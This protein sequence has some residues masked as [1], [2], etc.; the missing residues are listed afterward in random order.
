VRLL[1]HRSDRREDTPI[2]SLAHEAD[3]ARLGPRA[4]IPWWP[5]APLHNEAEDTTAVRSAALAIIAPSEHG[6]NNDRRGSIY[7][8]G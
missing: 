2:R 3:V 7:L 4:R 6:N 1:A 5:G 8:R